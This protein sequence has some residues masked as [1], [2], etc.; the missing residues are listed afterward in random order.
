MKKYFLFSLLFPIYSFS[1][2]YK[3]YIDGNNI[4]TK[5]FHSISPNAQLTVKFLNPSNHKL[6]ISQIQFA[7][8]QTKEDLNPQS[9]AQVARPREIKKLSF[10]LTGQAYEI[11]PSL[12]FNLKHVITSSDIELVSVKIVILESDTESGRDWITLNVLPKEVKVKM[13]DKI[14]MDKTHQK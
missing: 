10:N 14:M 9:S 6:K 8:S 3:F 2:E 12:S 5:V 4:E 13:Y 11:H 7:V 1:Q